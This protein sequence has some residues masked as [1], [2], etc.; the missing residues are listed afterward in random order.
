MFK[1]RTMFIMIPKAKQNKNSNQSSL[2][3]ASE[4]IHY[5]EKWVNKRK[6]SNTHT[7]FTI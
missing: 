6:E 2:E 3:N 4:P 7:D 1:P 5:F